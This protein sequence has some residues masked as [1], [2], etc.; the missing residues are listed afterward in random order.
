MKRFRTAGAVIKHI[1]HSRSIDWIL[2][3]TGEKQFASLH[4]SIHAVIARRAVFIARLEKHVHIV[5]SPYA[6][7]YGIVLQVEPIGIVAPLHIHAGI[8]I[9][10]RCARFRILFGRSH[11]LF[12]L[13]VGPVVIAEEIIGHLAPYPRVV[14]PVVIGRIQRVPIVRTGHASAVGRNRVPRK[15]RL[16][17]SIVR[18]MV[19]SVGHKI[20]QSAHEVSRVEIEFRII[21][22]AVHSV[23][24]Q[25]L[26]VILISHIHQS[27]HVF[28]MR[29][30]VF[31]DCFPKGHGGHD[32]RSHTIFMTD[33]EIC[34]RRT[35]KLRSPIAPTVHIAPHVEYFR[36]EKISRQCI[37]FLL[38]YGN[39]PEKPPVGT[40]I[41][42]H[43][44]IGIGETLFQFH[45]RNKKLLVIGQFGTDRLSGNPLSVCIGKTA[46]RTTQTHI[47]RMRGN[48]CIRYYRNPCQKNS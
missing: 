45:P 26:K 47:L 29:L 11:R 8:Y 48:L 2:A 16:R 41:H 6:Y 3:A 27:R 43:L 31:I 24:A 39:P 25:E 9:V 30:L 14:K 40:L 37:P 13:T 22:Y 38:A 15:L 10:G 21:A 32:L 1:G 34:G 33:V 7:R 17:Y 35:Q 36:I 28:A 23:I 5:R 19:G 18:R 46:F 12:Q 4:V 42:I 20:L 44:G